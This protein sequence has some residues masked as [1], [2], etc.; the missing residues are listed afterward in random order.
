MDGRNLL[1]AGDIEIIRGG[2][3]TGECR[4]VF[5]GCPARWKGWHSM[6]CTSRLQVPTS[7]TVT[8]GAKVFACRLTNCAWKTLL[9]TPV[10]PAATFRWNWCLVAGI[11][12]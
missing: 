2:C 6:R 1:Q 12:R 8:S 3:D 4:P 5:D 11:F 9:T 7:L 10:W